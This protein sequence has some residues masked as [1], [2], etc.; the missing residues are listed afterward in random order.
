MLKRDIRRSFAEV[1]AIEWRDIRGNVLT[2]AHPVKGHL[3]GDYEISGCLLAMLNMLPKKDKRVFP[4]HYPSLLTSFVR[5][6]KRVANKL[7]RPDIAEICFKSFRHWGGTTI[8]E[9]TNG[10][11]LIVK[12]MLRHKCITSTMKYVH[13]IKFEA[14][15]FEET[16][17]TTVDE[18]RNLGKTGWQ[19]YDELTVNGVQVHFYRRP[20]RSFGGT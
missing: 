17:A 7:Q 1:L 12:R 16:T 18:I 15:E 9:G 5:M 19:K 2:I 11:V 4:V 20:K 8:A 6:R 13:A 14:K 3:A 10:N